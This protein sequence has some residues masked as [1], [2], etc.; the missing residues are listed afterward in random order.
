MAL[1]NRPGCLFTGTTLLLAV[2]SLGAIGAV[3][4]AAL[5]VIQ[6]YP[7]IDLAR[8]ARTHSALQNSSNLDGVARELLL[9]LHS[10]LDSVYFFG[11]AIWRWSILLLLPAMLVGFLAPK[12]ARPTSRFAPAFWAASLLATGLTAV[13]VASYLHRFVARPKGHLDLGRA[14]A[15]VSQ[16][17]RVEQ[18]V[19]WGLLI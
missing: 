12:T 6:G 15:A 2:L 16:V 4:Y 7:Y 3:T 17:I 19:P 18:V 5:L 11:I 14:K 13:A 9:A 1:P 8:T 10:G